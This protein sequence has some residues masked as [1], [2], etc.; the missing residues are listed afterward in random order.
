MKA[1]LEVEVIDDYPPKEGYTKFV[2]E[3]QRRMKG[4][5]SGGIEGK[6]KDE[7]NLGQTGT[8]PIILKAIHDPWGG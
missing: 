5:W 4:D 1:G 3:R 7:Y 8:H 6:P 2:E